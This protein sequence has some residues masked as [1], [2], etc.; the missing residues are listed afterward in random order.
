MIRALRNENNTEA[1]V[2]YFSTLP[3]LQHRQR[4]FAYLQPGQKLAERS[5]EFG[6]TA[7]PEQVVFNLPALETDLLPQRP[8]LPGKPLFYLGAKSWLMPEWKGLLYPQRIAKEAYISA[9]G[10]QYNS[11]ELNTTFYSIPRRELVLRWCEAMPQ[12]FRFCPKFPQIISHE[13]DLRKQRLPLSDFLGTLEA[14]GSKLGVAFL[15]LPPKFSPDRLGEIA[16]LL[17]AA[18]ALSLYIAVE[19]RHTGFFDAPHKEYVVEL[20]QRHNSS[21]VVTDTAGRRDLLHGTLCSRKWLVR[22]VATGVEEIDKL[23]IDQWLQH[24]QSLAPHL[25]EFYFLNHNPEGRSLAELSLYLYGCLDTE[26]PWLTRGPRRI[27]T[28]GTQFQLF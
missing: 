14:F 28:Y 23:R 19:F 9:Y 7:H 27:S 4:Q 5:M 18:G 16:F 12:D 10:E 15:Q 11:I 17:E 26:I 2:I 3:A 20:L 1:N 21:W 6:K 8:D 13:E 25:D 24:M 22:F